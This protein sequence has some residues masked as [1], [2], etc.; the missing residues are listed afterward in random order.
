MFRSSALFRN[1]AASTTSSAVLRRCCAPTAATAMLAA[2]ASALAA[3]RIGAAAVMAGAVRFN[4]TASRARLHD[5]TLSEVQGEETQHTEAEPPVPQ[6][7][8]V[9]HELGTNFFTAKRTVGDETLELYCP[10]RSPKAT[11]AE[12]DAG[13]EDGAA[14]QPFSVVITRSGKPTAMFC[15]LS[16]HSG[17]L[18][19][20]QIRMLDGADK[21][22]RTDFLDMHR[23][24][25][26]KL[27]TQYEGPG[28]FEL[29][30]PFA[31]PLFAFLEDRG[32]SDDFGEFV[33][34]FAYHIEQREYIN[35]LQKMA[36][37]TK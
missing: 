8:S 35:W 26:T 12:R 31:D 6:G 19:V 37:F 28:I 34:L 21:L 25:G 2:S 5:Q 18:V 11:A 22:T 24:I 9:E 32:L 23:G 14:A 27:L 10:L 30:E 1:V 3:P 13:R 33:A 36:S 29:E 15:N 20:E 16:V 4:G 7:W 17:E